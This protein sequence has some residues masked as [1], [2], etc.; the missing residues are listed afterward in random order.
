M[1]RSLVIAVPSLAALATG[2]CSTYPQQAQPRLFYEVPCGMPGA[3]RA[4]VHPS[5]PAMAD[6]SGSAVA[7][8]APT[9]LPSAAPAGR[10]PLCLAQAEAVPPRYARRPYSFYNDSWWPYQSRSFFGL[11]VGLGGG[12]HGGHGGVVHHGGGRHHH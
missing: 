7:Q 11:S 3:F 2:A 10:Q 1:R 6:P 4:D 9:D 5:D 8:P 12:H